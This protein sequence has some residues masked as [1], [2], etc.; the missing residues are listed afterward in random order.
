MSME[1]LFKTSQLILSVSE[2]VSKIVLDKNH[3]NENVKINYVKVNI[4]DI[5]SNAL[6]K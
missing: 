1:A 6:I 5:F 4:H 3:F 2:T